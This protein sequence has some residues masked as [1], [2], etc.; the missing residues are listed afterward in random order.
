MFL[1][2]TRKYTH[3]LEEWSLVSPK[4]IFRCVSLILR[5]SGQSITGDFLNKDTNFRV[6]ES[7]KLESSCREHCSF[8]MFRTCL[9]KLTCIY[10]WTLLL[11]N[12]CWVVRISMLSVVV[13]FSCVHS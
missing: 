7:E 12:S 10:Q 9:D 11:D 1:K 13:N 5:L 8:L 2:V 6:C 4:C 3:F